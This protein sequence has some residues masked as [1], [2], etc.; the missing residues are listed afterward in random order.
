MMAGDERWDVFVSHNRQN[1]PWVRR[2]VAQW[3][4]LKL[5]VFFDE[6]SIP[7][8]ATSCRALEDGLKHSRRVVLLISPAALAAPWIE[9]ETAISIYRSPSAADR[10]LIPVIIEPIDWEKDV[11]L[12]VQRLSRVDLSDPARRRDEYH[13]LLRSLLDDDSRPLPDPPRFDDG[14]GDP[15]PRFLL[16]PKPSCFGREGPVKELVRTLLQED[17]PPTPILGGPGIGKTTV[18]L[19]ALHDPRR[20]AA[21]RRAAVLRPVRCGPDPRRGRWP[22][23]QPARR[24]GRPRAGAPGRGGAGAAGPPSWSSTT[25]R[26][27][28]RPIG[29]PPRSCSV[30]WPRSP[31]W[32]WSPPS[33]AGNWPAGIAWREPIRVEP[34]SPAAARGGVPRRARQGEVRR[35]SPPGGPARGGRSRAAGGRPAG[36]LRPAR[37]EPDGRLEPVAHPED[38]DPAVAWMATD[39]C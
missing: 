8:G 35:R 14:T 19:A 31:A 24:A 39:G 3:R 10:R 18:T 38:G 37:A 15:L 29:G 21:L 6:D 34:L 25:S 2:L 16:P 9:L 28:G 4:E 5:R 32:C 12:S 22:V 33:A 27:R 11:Q 1:K 26:R 23:G 30:S 17:P 13:R 36:P 7:P 20:G